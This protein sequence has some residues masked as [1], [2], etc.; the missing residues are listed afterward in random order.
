M[1]LVRPEIAI[2]MLIIRPEARSTLGLRP[3]ARSA[4]SDPHG[5]PEHAGAAATKKEIVHGE[6]EDRQ[7]AVEEV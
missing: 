1:A 5:N 7:Y 4:P 2:P 3:Q 6:A